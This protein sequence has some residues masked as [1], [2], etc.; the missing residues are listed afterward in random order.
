MSSNGVWNWNY[1]IRNERP[2][3]IIFKPP[4]EIP[5]STKPQ[6]STSNNKP[7]TTPS[8]A[9][10]IVPTKKKVDPLYFNNE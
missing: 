7:A 2:S 5:L 4:Q 3:Q 1:I 10:N 8:Q 6:D 9:Q